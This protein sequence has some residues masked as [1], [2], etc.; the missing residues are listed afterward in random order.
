MQETGNDTPKMT[1]G[2]EPDIQQPGSFR[3][4]GLL[5]PSQLQSV[6]DN[7]G[8]RGYRDLAAYVWQ[9]WRFD[10]KHG[11]L[12][13]FLVP[14]KELDFQ[15]S[16]A[17]SESS[18]YRATPPFCLA[19]ALDW[20]SNRVGGLN[21]HVMVDYG[22]GAGRVMILGAEAGF[23]RVIGLELSGELNAQAQKNLARYRA[24]NAETQFDVV[25]EN[26]TLYTVPPE[27]TVFYFFNPF[28]EAFFRLAIDNIRRSVQAHPR[29]IYLLGFQSWRYNIEGLDMIG[30]VTGVKIYSNAARPDAFLAPLE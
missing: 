29:V 7:L 5:A 2:P 13:E 9:E 23:A 20:L 1:A 21:D 15:D 22:S 16:A 24:R 10:R 26:A 3:L 30:D 6:R 8:L 27:T 25:Q 11:V 18:R 12:T 14:A 4:L 19:T 28:S 17:Q